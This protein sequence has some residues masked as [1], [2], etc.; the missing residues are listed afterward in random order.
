LQDGEL[1]FS[2]RQLPYP[3]GKVILLRISPNLT[4]LEPGATLRRHMRYPIPV[5]EYSCFF[6]KEP[7]S[8]IEIVESRSARFFCDLVTGAAD[9]AFRAS[10][11]IGGLEIVDVTKLGNVT[12]LESNSVPCAVKVAR[13][14]DEFQRF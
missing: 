7:D 5:E 6:P 2:H 3:I 1:R 8:G 14:R 13:R 9:G 4:A 11:S 12:T 10:P